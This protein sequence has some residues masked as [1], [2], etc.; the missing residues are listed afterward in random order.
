MR[1]IKFRAWNIFEEHFVDS[2]EYAVTFNGIIFK[3]NLDSDTYNNLISNE[4]LKFMQYTGLKDKKNEEIYEGDIVKWGHIKNREES[5]HRVAFVELFPSLQ[6]HILHY[7]D[8]KSLEKKEGDNYVFGFH[9]FIY[10]DTH[11]SLEVIG[12]IYENPELLKA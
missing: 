11:N 4:N 1:E 12:N 2:D 3:A 9:N 7:I 5:W 6:F 8:G 10:K